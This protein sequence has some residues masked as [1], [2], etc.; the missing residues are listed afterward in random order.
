MKRTIIDYK[1]IGSLPLEFESVL[2]G[3]TVFDS[4]CSPEARVYFIDKDGGYYLKRSSV[5]ALEKE[6][7]MTAYFHSKGLSC[8]V[9]SYLTDGGYDW[10]LTRRIEG[11]DCTHAQYLSEPRRLAILLGERLRE[12]HSLDFSGCPVQDRMKSYRALAEENYAR[13]AYDLSYFDGPSEV[14]AAW[15]EIEECGG[16]LSGRALLHGDYCLPNVML[17]DWRFSG[18]IDVGNGGVGDPHIDLY[19]GAWTLNFNLHTEE[20]RDVF[21]DA[22][23]RDAVD[24][25]KIRTVS[26]FECF[27]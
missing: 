7:K 3:A 2:S 13:G 23:G 27:G 19:W 9:I 6:A 18:F 15:R 24:L 11:E 16:S 26:A 22:Y 5:G 17:D 25:D 12:L 20:Y 14:R 1:R 8:E 10:M 4:S 21:F